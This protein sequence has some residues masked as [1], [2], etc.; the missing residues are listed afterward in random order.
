MSFRSRHPRLAA[1]FLL[2]FLALPLASAPNARVPAAPATPAERAIRDVDQS[3]AGQDWVAAAHQARLLIQDTQPAPVRLQALERLAIAL[4]GLGE[5]R[6]SAKTAQQ[7]EILFRDQEKVRLAKSSGYF[8][9][10]SAYDGVRRYAIGLLRKRQAAAKYAGHAKQVVPA[11]VALARRF[12]AHPRRRTYALEAAEKLAALGRENEA[13]PWFL[14]ALDTGLDRSF[15]AKAKYSDNQVQLDAVAKPPSLDLVTRALAGL[16]GQPAPKAGRKTVGAKQSGTT[17]A[18][19]FHAALALTRQPDSRV[20]VAALE[21][22]LKTP[23]FSVR[24][25]ADIARLELARTHL[26]IGH[27]LEAAEVL[28]HIAPQRGALLKRHTGLGRAIAAHQRFLQGMTVDLMLDRQGAADHFAAAADLGGD[29]L[30]DAARS[31]QAGALELAGEWKAARKLYRKL[32]ENSPAEWIR[33]SANIST[34][35][36]G[37]LAKSPFPRSDFITQLPDDRETHGDWYLGYGSEHYVLCAHKSRYDL[38]G[39]PGPELMLDFSTS[40]PKEPSR[41]WVSARSSDDPAMLWNPRKRVRLP[42]NRDDRGEQYPIGAGPDLLMDA[43]VPEGRHI[44]SL[45]FV[46][47][48][49]FYEA[50][51]RYTIEI[52]FNNRLLALAD[53]RDF[54]AGVY[55]RFLVSGPCKLRV[56]LR[57]DASMNVLLQGVFL[58]PIPALDPSPLPAERD[59]PASHDTYGQ[60]TRRL[61]RYPRR[62][63]SRP[64]VL[65]SLASA[66]D[67]HTKIPGH[68]YQ[69]SRLLFAAGRPRCARRAFGAFAAIVPPGRLLPVARA[70]A[71]QM[72][73]RD[74]LFTRRTRDWPAGTHTIDLL[75]TRWFSCWSA[76]SGTG[77]TPPGR[78]AAEW[79]GELVSLVRRDGPYATPYARKRALLELERHAPERLSAPLLYRAGSQFKREGDAGQAAALL[80]RA[81]AATP[82]QSTEMRV[83]SYLLE[84]APEAGVPL[85]EVRTL[86]ARIVMLAEAQGIAYMLPVF[87]RQAAEAYVA[88]GKYEEAIKLLKHMPPET[89]NRL[90]ERWQTAAATGKE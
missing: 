2:L 63:L 70:L 13:M 61:A 45:Y 15:G 36:L 59:T 32:A 54:G 62:L 31:E 27:A 87:H 52:R 57:R 49:R 28:S 55:K 17:P 41:L 69:R 77:E 38:E 67:P 50:N 86:H 43:I 3:L 22:L 11:A 75:N 12:P 72:A 7:A 18:D 90:R 64:T 23:P 42:A 66:L 85:E 10:R 60:Y 34:T 83:S 51:R 65:L 76:A 24:P 74:P 78:S 89:A 48:H 80:R 1:Y 39:G 46:N 35:R 84:V 37:E 20:A 30:H 5:P 56:C 8:R 14:A 44:L 53:V 33:R 71:N 25:F 79:V 16:T 88:H 73:A 58:D 82:S 26:R 4:A 47:D 6:E 68:Q 21:T 19:Q 9:N 81:L 40:D 29:A